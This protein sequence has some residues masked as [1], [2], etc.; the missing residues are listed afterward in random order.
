MGVQGASGA[1]GSSSGGDSG[2]AAGASS[3]TDSAAGSSGAAASGGSGDSGGTDGASAGGSDASLGGE[4][5]TTGT[6]ADPTTATQQYAAAGSSLSAAQSGSSTAPDA[7]AGGT[8]QGG[9]YSVRV[10]GGTRSSEAAAK[11]PQLNPQIAHPELLDQSLQYAQQLGAGKAV[12]DLLGAAPAQGHVNAMGDAFEVLGIS[13]R[14]IGRLAEDA[15]KGGVDTAGINPPTAD[16]KAAQTA[17]ADAARARASVDPGAAKTLQAHSENVGL[18]SIGQGAA[19]AYPQFSA[20]GLIS[21]T[22][23]GT[24]ASGKYYSSE[25]AARDLLF[26]G[27][28]VSKDAAAFQDKGFVSRDYSRSIASGASQLGQTKI[29]ADLPPGLVKAQAEKTFGSAAPIT[30][31][32]DAIGTVA[33]GLSLQRGME[34]DVAGNLKGQAGKPYDQ[35]AAVASALQKNGISLTPEQISNR[36]YEAVTSPEFAHHLDGLGDSDKQAATS[37]ALGTLGFF[38]SELAG[39]AAAGHDLGEASKGAVDGRS[40][41]QAMGSTSPEQALAQASPAERG[42]AMEGLAANVLGAARFATGAVAASPKHS[43][44][45]QEATKFGVGLVKIWN[46]PTF[47]A[48][49]RGFLTNQMSQ[50]RLA[51]ESVPSNVAFEQLPGG[52]L[53]F[54]AG[55]FDELKHSAKYLLDHGV[56][57]TKDLFTGTL[58]P[59]LAAGSLAAHISTAKNGGTADK[60]ENGA[61]IAADAMTIA[62]GTSDF[63]KKTAP[64]WQGAAAEG[65]NGVALNTWGLATYAPAFLGTWGRHLNNAVTNN[66]SGLG[67]VVYGGA[68]ISGSVRGFMDRSLG[69]A[70]QAGKGA[71]FVGSL[72][73]LHNGAM[74]LGLANLYRANNFDPRRAQMIS[75]IVGAMAAMGQV[76]AQLAG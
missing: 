43:V 65:R 35:H 59:M 70:E 29:D 12:T 37:E 44:T 68:G 7:Q 26:G 28:G 76:G 45:D 18:T 54:S 67:N 55:D 5:V 9:N 50:A 21:S 31:A 39:S 61:K 53:S 40:L 42:A 72:A 6:G 11:D 63:I 30:S 62:G 4:H 23:A 20:D 19:S 24:K 25:A 48:D 58:S 36:M 34:A 49:P 14:Q 2:S 10:S 47:R 71:Q 56:Q 3:G 15:G 32:D 41:L 57:G 22:E 17:F 27:N 13:N 52:G 73:N 60:V 16:G 33:A 46:D 51:G 8:A 64:L 69:A 1:S 66:L 38:N 74:S 75:S